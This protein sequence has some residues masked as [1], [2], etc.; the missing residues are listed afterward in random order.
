MSYITIYF[1]D[2]PVFLCDQ[3]TQEINEYRHHPDAVF[4]DEI[5]TAAINSLLHEIKKPQFHAG[6]I[7]GKD[8]E[9]LKAQFFKHF[10][11]IQAGGGLVKNKNEE[12][13]MIFR[14]GKWDLPKGKLDENESIEECAKREVQEETGLENV[15]ILKPIEITYHTYVQFGKHNLKE[16][17]WYLMK[18]SG[19]EKLIPQ[20][21]EDIT[22]IIWAKKEDLPKYL[23]NTFPTIGKVLKHA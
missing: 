17:H 18:A 3:I 19:D 12:I 14:R 13:L 20:T 10:H 5:S 23:S 21:E 16:S 4:I 1:D 11:L 7:L 6:I 2:K 15:K 22:E 9:K 8:F